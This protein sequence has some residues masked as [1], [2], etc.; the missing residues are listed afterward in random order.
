MF[1]TAKAKL[2]LTMLGKAPLSLYAKGGESYLYNARTAAI[3]IRIGAANAVLTALAGTG[4]SPVL[5]DP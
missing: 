1:F 5:V 2:A 4:R 3:Y